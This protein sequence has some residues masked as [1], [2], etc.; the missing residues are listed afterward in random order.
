MTLSKWQQGLMVKDSSLK[1]KNMSKVCHLSEVKHAV[2][3]SGDLNAALVWYS[4][5]QKEVGHQI[6]W[7]LN[8]I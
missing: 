6:T 2:T 7:D 4:N 3:Y 8:A 1:G 5:G